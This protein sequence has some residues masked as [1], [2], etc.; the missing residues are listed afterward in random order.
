L[1]ALLALALALGEYAPAPCD[2][3]AECKRVQGHGHVC[4]DG[5][6]DIYLDRN[7]LL[8]MI[9]LKK[10]R[11]VLE[12]Y[13]LYPSIIPSI[14]YAPQN[15][16]VFGVTTLTGV[17]LGDPRTTTISNVGLVALYTS[18]D[19]I[20][21]FSRNNLLLAENAW[22]LQGDY[23]F[24]A[25]KQVTYGLGSAPAARASSR[26]TSTSSSSTRRCSGASPAACMW[27]RATGSTAISP[28]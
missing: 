4:V 25:T 11:G 15:G 17:Y 26:C 27:A 5:R 3:S 20:I 8:E 19:Q 18:M 10:S 14:G 16:V 2:D 12:S 22:Q 24:L 23:R 6:C 1:A 28:S 7:D 13:R 9:G 21:V